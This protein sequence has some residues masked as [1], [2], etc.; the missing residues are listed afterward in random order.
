M[1]ALRGFASADMRSDPFASLPLELALAQLVY[2]PPPPAAVAPGPDSR[3]W[4]WT[5]RRIKVSAAEMVH[6]H[7]GGRVVSDDHPRRVVNASNG[8]SA[9]ECGPEC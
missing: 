4:R 1:A 8:R 6:H 7:R 3:A 9:H 5:T 2:A